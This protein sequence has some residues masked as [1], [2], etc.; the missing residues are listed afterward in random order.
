MSKE[1][2]WGYEE[3]SVGYGEAIANILEGVSPESPLYKALTYGLLP[4]SGWDKKDSKIVDVQI[5]SNA[6]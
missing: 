5:D 2:Y 6:F 4:G 1:E 3:P